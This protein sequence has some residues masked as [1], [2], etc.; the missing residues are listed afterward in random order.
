MKKINL[1][2]SLLFF[3]T[4]TIYAVVPK[5][6]AHRGYW[7]TAGSAQNSIRSLVKADSIGCY[8]SEFDVWMTLDSVLF[9]NHDPTINGVEIQK[10]LAKDV[11]KEKLVNGEYIPT[12]EKYLQTAK[13]LKTRLVLEM[14][15]H[16]SRKQ[17]KAAIIKSI[18]LV[19]KYG[20]EKKTDYI[21]FSPY[22][23]KDYIKYA[24]KG[25]QV[26]YLNGDFIPSQIKYMKGKGIDYSYK[27]MTKHPEWVKQTQDQNMEVN[28][29]T[30][31]EPEELQWCIDNG[32]D[33]ITT[34]N[35][36][37]ALKMVKKQ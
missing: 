16:D 30:V 3:A 17:E 21:A 27:V 6:I 13:K 2:L 26:Y 25:S 22:A 19:K 29:W 7:D 9:V 10:S 4:G 12:L 36:E 34:N 23:F 33:Y 18:E 11:A 32:V 8:A 5:V 35:P 37:L 31:T 1:L 28:V 15:S 14:K 24:P 20:L